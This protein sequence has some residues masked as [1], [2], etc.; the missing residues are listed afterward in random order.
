MSNR[1]FPV[2]ISSP[3]GGGKTT[4]AGALLA[5]LPFLRKS[6][7][8]TTRQPRP[9][10]RPGVDYEFVTGEVFEQRK[11]AGAFAE[12]AS[13]HGH[14]YGT[15]REY[16]DE[17]CS[18]GHC[19]L[20]VIDIQ[21]GRAVRRAY[22]AALLVFLMPPS[23]DE[24]ARRLGARRSEPDARLEARLGNAPGEIAAGLEYDYIVMNA[25]IE[26]AIEQVRQV[27]LRERETRS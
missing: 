7:S 18:A 10:E 3:S 1:G 9:G 8:T 4:I 13:V 20:L 22:P 23:L 15:P 6:R 5:A 21:G 27:L 19:P 16:V 25:S 12:W 14:G 24:V 17:T 26:L 2:V 11:A